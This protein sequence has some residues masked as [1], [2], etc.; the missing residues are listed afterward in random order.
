MTGIIRW[1]DMESCERNFPDSGEQAVIIWQMAAP[2]REHRHQIILTLGCW[3]ICKKK[4]TLP[5]GRLPLENP[6]YGTIPTNF[7]ACAAQ[8]RYLMQLIS[9]TI[10]T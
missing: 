5:A 4:T 7:V 9:A 1:V 10:I 3:L 8:R 2:N 6:Y